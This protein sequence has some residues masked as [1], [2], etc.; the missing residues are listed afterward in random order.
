M[1]E[2]F[3]YDFGIFDSSNDFY[4]PAALGADFDVDVEDPFEEPCP[5]NSL[6]FGFLFFLLFVSVAGGTQDWFF[7]F[8][9]DN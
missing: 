7:F 4:F 2:D 3:L 1:I 8:L 9:R 6:C 5:G